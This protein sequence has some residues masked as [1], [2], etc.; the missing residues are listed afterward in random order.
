MIRSTFA[1]LVL[2]VLFAA[3]RAPAT[4]S[5]PRGYTLVLIKTG[6]QSGKLSKEENERVFAGH[7]ANMQRLSEERKLVVAGPFGGARSDKSLR[8][9]F[10]LD[11]EDRALARAWAETDPPTQA[12][13]F[14][15]EYHDLRT[16]APLVEHH[17]R[18][19]A[20]LAKEKAAGHERKL[21]EGMRTYVILTAE[22]GDLAQRELADL[23]AGGQVFALADLDRDRAWALI[24]AQDLAGAG[25]LLGSRIDRLG[26]HTLDEWFGSDGLSRLSRP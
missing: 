9:I 8:G 23:V 24:D 26:A 18:E 14:A 22:H 5:E 17:D 21:G 6:P 25:S 4:G 1:L 11:T 12:G 13:V 15:L 3:C 7:F 20:A 10:V 2:S 19:L 16:T